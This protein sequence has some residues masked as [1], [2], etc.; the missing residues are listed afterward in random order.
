MCCWRFSQDTSNPLYKTIGEVTED[1]LL[2]RQDKT[3]GTF[4]MLIKQ[5]IDLSKHQSKSNT[6]NSTNSEVNEQY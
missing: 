2:A 4:C 1:I 5:T 6:E 3:R